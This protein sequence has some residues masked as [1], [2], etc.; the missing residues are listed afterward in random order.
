MPSLD[1]VKAIIGEVERGERDSDWPAWEILTSITDD[2]EHRIKAL[3]DPKITC[4]SSMYRG[5]SSYFI[6]ATGQTS[7]NSNPDVWFHAANFSRLTNIE[8]NKDVYDR[9][10]IKFFIVEGLKREPNHLLLLYLL[11]KHLEETIDKIDPEAS[12]DACIELVREVSHAAESCL[13]VSQSSEYNRYISKQKLL[14]DLGVQTP[15]V[16]TE[17]LTDAFESSRNALERVAADT[18][19]TAVTPPTPPVKKDLA[20]VVREAA[21]NRD[22]N[23]Q[24][25]TD[26]SGKMNINVLLNGGYDTEKEYHAALEAEARRDVTAT[27]SKQSKWNTKRWLLRFV[28][29]ALV[30]FGGYYGIKIGME[31]EAEKRIANW[32]VNHPNAD[33]SAPNH[34]KKK[35]R[36]RNAKTAAVAFAAPTM[37]EF[38]PWST[39]ILSVLGFSLVLSTIV[40]LAGWSPLFKIFGVVAI[41]GAVIAFI[42]LL[43]G[44]RDV[45]KHTRYD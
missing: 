18:A 28:V 23:V 27:M 25:G 14:L 42:G 31:Q 35:H 24:P 30:V 21:K 5:P 17:E 20:S 2:C 15:F 34:F 38:P 40:Q 9:N 37:P 7:L 6:W 22:P 11:V 44:V 36:A 41:I 16:S 13:R 39:V 4:Y 33:Q 19:D 1:N 10:I 43:I 26:P 29:I 32:Q 8:I 45:R 12:R 3:L